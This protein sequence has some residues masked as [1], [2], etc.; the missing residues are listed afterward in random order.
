MGYPQPGLGAALSGKPIPKAAPG[1]GLL[2]LPCAIFDLPGEISLNH[3]T[4]LKVSC[5]KHLIVDRRE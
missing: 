1:I 3:S 2:E 4:V 5:R